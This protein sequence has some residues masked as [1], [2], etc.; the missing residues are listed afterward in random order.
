MYQLRHDL[1]FS[2]FADEMNDP[3]HSKEQHTASKDQNAS[4][5]VCKR[6]TRPEQLCCDE[7]AAERQKPQ[8]PQDA[9]NDWQAEDDERNDQKL[10]SDGTEQR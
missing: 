7:V 5:P 2:L 8:F 10:V 6:P 3:C 4:V 9:D 1:F